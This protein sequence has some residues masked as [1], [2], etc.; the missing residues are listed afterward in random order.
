MPTPVTTR[1][2]TIRQ[3]IAPVGYASPLTCL[4]PERGYQNIYPYNHLD[5]LEPGI[6]TE[7]FDALVVENEYLRATV[8]P[9]MGCRLYSLFDKLS[10]QEV[11][12]RPDPVLPMPILLRGAYIPL[13]LEFNF[14]CGHNV[15]AMEPLPCEFI[16]PGHGAEGIRIHA[17][18]A[19]SGLDT[20]VD[21]IL[22]P[23]ERLLRTR[24]H[25]RNPLP[26]RNGFM[27]W[28][29]PSVIQTPEM[30]FQCKARMSH[31]FTDYNTYPF[32]DG[33]DLRIAKNR[34]FASDT[35]AVDAQEDWFG[36]YSP[37]LRRGALHLAP[38]SQMRGQKFFSWG[39]DDYGL[40]QARKMGIGGHGYMEFQAGILETQF[41]F[42]H[43]EAGG[44]YVCDEMWFPFHEMG[45][46]S[47]ANEFFALSHEPAALRMTASRKF[48]DLLVSITGSD[49]AEMETTFDQ[50]VPGATLALRVPPDFN[51]DAY[52]V[53]IVSSE[54]LLLEHDVAAP[55]PAGPAEIAEKQAWLDL[56]PDS[57]AHRVE[58]AF[59]AYKARQFEKAAELAQAVG[60]GD[61]SLD[62]EAAM[63][64]KEIEWWRQNGLP[65]GP[66]AMPG[67]PSS[68]PVL[69]S[70]WESLQARLR[71]NPR[72][73]EAHFALGNFYSWRD[74][75][76]AHGHWKKASESGPAHWQALRNIAV[77]QLRRG[78]SASALPLYREI[79]ALAPPHAAL[80]AEFLLALRLEG[81]HEESLARILSLPP[82][83]R[84]DYRVLKFHIYALCDAGRPDD[85]L[86][87]LCSS[88]QMR[89]WEGEVLPHKYYLDCLLATGLRE[90][91]AGRFAHAEKAFRRMLRYPASLGHGKP[92]VCNEAIAYYHLGLVAESMGQEAKARAL[93]MVAAAQD[94]AHAHHWISYRE[95][96]FFGGLAARKLDDQEAVRTIAHRLSHGY[97]GRGSAEMLD[98]PIQMQVWRRDLAAA[99]GF[100]L[101]GE[102]AAARQA[103]ENAQRLWGPSWILSHA[104]QLAAGEPSRPAPL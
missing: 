99:R 1:R 50:V 56:Q 9:R 59:R 101:T 6:V 32:V 88:P 64:L 83:E 82:R 102:D 73:A 58:L 63:I 104:L 70:Q 45:N 24:V 53:R 90:L 33:L 93:W 38:R 57:D 21:I 41:E 17:W 87:L 62:S 81:R 11:F 27:Y 47:H 48:R 10:G 71:K 3:Q 96:E 2:E 51:P 84:D 35:F 30:A 14:P 89:L 91:Q 79:M 67:V 5:A 4:M 77:S 40:G 95:N 46:I 31:F 98:I 103:I 13:G 80:E 85:A 86:T 74:A 42:L 94:Q 25:F 54:G 76:K 61:K 65:E 18:N 78:D 8:V 37:E 19:V 28:A 75:D 69:H 39:F 66:D 26:V 100:I 97:S 23:G 36:F 34:R 12:A 15:L 16:Q 43:L 55:I 68:H 20:T 44:E 49:G 72:D 60:E 22:R 92:L 52:S 7:T 29:N